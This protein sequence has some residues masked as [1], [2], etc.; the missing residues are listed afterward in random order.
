MK[1]CRNCGCVND[2][3]NRCCRNCGRPFESE[4]ISVQSEAE[5]RDERTVDPVLA[6]E[7]VS[8]EAKKDFFDLESAAAEETN[9]LFGILPPEPPLSEPGYIDFDLGEENEAEVR[10]EKGVVPTLKAVASSP[11]FLV[12]AVF[13]SCTLALHLAQVLFTFDEYYDVI[14]HWLYIYGIDRMGAGVVSVFAVMGAVAV[15]LVSAAPMLLYVMGLWFHYAASRKKADDLSVGG[16]HLLSAGSIIDLIISTL[17]VVVC[18]LIGAGLFL[19]LSYY[20]TEVRPII[21]NSLAVVGALCAAG[22]LS[23]LYHSLALSTLGSLKAAAKGTGVCRMS[24]FVMTANL[25]CALV[26]SAVAGFYLALADVLSVAMAVSEM[27]ML[28]SL[29]LVMVRYKTE[30]KENAK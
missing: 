10:E 22:I 21:I 15:R 3:I 8:E 16:L 6:G 29:T 2:N 19:S 9:A 30:L 20:G 17:V 11:M 27:L 28:V 12:L 1:S 25:L 7:V 13:T 18:V 14:C 26:Y 24:V 5:L 4:D 23:I